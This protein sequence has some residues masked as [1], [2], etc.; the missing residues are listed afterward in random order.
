MRRL[1]EGS[2]ENR[3]PSAYQGEFGEDYIDAVPEGEWIGR[4]FM[5][6]MDELWDKAVEAFISPCLRNEMKRSIACQS[7][8]VQFATCVYIGV[9]IVSSLEDLQQVIMTAS[10]LTLSHKGVFHMCFT[11]NNLQGAICFFD[12]ET[13]GG[14]ERQIAKTAIDFAFEVRSTLVDK[15][16]PSIVSLSSGEFYT[17]VLGNLTRSDTM[18]VGAVLVRAM[19]LLGMIT[20]VTKTIFTPNV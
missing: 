7:S 16:I 14:N 10:K 15:G 20:L 12:G 17:T 5:S 18:I 2:E 8:S 1:S 6:E 3:D 4:D 11:F 9:D 19:K 13:T